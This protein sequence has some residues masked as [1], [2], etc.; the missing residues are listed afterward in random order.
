MVSPGTTEVP[1]VR[2]DARGGNHPGERKCKTMSKQSKKQ[3]VAQPVVRDV[4]SQIESIQTDL[5]LGAGYK[6]VER[7]QTRMRSERV[8][9]AFLEL[10]ATLAEKNGG[11]IAGMSF[12]AAEARNVLAF[13]KTARA[14][15][16]AARELAQRAQDASVQQRIAVVDRGMGI[17]RALGRIVRTAEGNDL[18]PV[19]E[20]MQ[21]LV[22]RP[23]RTKKKASASA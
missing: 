6:R 14:N 2:P 13:V 8:P 23:G 10:L 21:S 15:A 5:G 22:R 11:M 12:D 3:T 18:G 19:Y 20:Q 7:R 16:A 1:R 4:V 9:D 17:Y